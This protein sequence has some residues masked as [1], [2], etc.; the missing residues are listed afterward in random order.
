ML[1]ITNCRQVKGIPRTP[2]YGYPTGTLYSIPYRNTAYTRYAVCYTRYARIFFNQQA[3]LLAFPE[4]GD[5]MNYD[6]D[7]EKK[8]YDAETLARIFSA[9]DFRVLFAMGVICQTTGLSA[10]IFLRMLVNARRKDDDV[11]F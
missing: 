10:D 2:I 8:E 6:I 4:G 1:Q 3:C 7:V 5:S 9:S 11:P